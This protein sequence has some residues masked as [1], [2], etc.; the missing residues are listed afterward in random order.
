MIAPTAEIP[1]GVRHVQL[2]AGRGYRVEWHGA[3]VGQVLRSG[4]SRWRALDE[5]GD[6]I[7]ATRQRW[8]WRTR[9]RATAAIV[10]DYLS[11]VPA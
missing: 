3:L 4:S 8:T 9:H 2:V 5:H 10:A 1:E 11:R 6:P 7:A